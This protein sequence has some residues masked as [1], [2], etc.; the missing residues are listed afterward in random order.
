MRC[1]LF[2]I[3]A[4]STN[5]TVAH[6]FAYR[7]Y[8]DKM[9]QNIMSFFESRFQE[10]DRL[11][12][13]FKTSTANYMIMDILLL[14]DPYFR[15]LT[16]NDNGDARLSPLPISRAM[17]DPDTYLELTDAVLDKIMNANIPELRQ[18]QLLIKRFREHRMYA[19][20]DK[21]II[22]GKKKWMQ[23]LWDMSE[24]DIAREVMKMHEKGMPS[25]DNEN[26]LVA[27]DIIVEK[28]KI[29]HGKGNN[30]RE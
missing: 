17:T 19:K 23:K 7:C 21:T 3:A 5:R 16:I 29:N 28:R 9:A 1:V 11:Y 22:E 30:N 14:A 27:D 24:G 6:F 18:A 2:A 20:I 4:S 26:T 13:H 8:P 25:D 12:Q 15:L 10:H